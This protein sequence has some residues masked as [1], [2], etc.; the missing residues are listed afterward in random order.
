MDMDKFLKHRDD[1][2]QQGVD[3]LKARTIGRHVIELVARDGEISVA[4]LFDS[5][6]SSIAPSMKREDR[7]VTEAALAHLQ[8]LLELQG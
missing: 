4:S 6:K 5:L 8:E 3:F 1:L 2:V 7:L